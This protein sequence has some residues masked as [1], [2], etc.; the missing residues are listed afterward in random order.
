MKAPDHIIP[1]GNQLGEG[2]QWHAGSGLWWTDVEGRAL[3]H[4]DPASG[5][6]TRIAAPQ[7]IGSFARV[8]GDHRLFCAFEQ[9]FAYF[10]TASGQ[11]DWL[12]QIESP[13]SGRRFN[14]GRADPTGRFLA[15]TMVESGKKDGAALHRLDRDGSTARL[16]EGVMISNGLC[17]SPDGKTMYH[18]DS[19]TQQ[20][21]AFDYDSGAGTVSNRR[22]LATTP[23]GA[24]PD[25]AIV[26]SA[27]C[28][29]SAQWGASRIVRFRPDGDV[30]RVIELPTSHPTCAALGGADLRDLYVTSARQGLDAATLAKEPHAGDV[31]VFRVDCPGLPEAAYRPIKTS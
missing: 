21:V 25:G 16:M 15:G 30:D 6:Q 28:I 27:G 22:I 31:F 12:H 17:W 19:P 13:D 1:A 5:H 10:D 2:I 7:R 3:H 23:K 14:D 18:A 26:D 4:F 9:G 24:Y 11:V 29:W 8:E 20:M